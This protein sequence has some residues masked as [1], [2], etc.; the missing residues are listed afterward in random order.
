ME[1]QLTY[2][3]GHGQT[4]R[5][6]DGGEFFLLELLDGVLV[7]SQ[8]Q[9]CT[10]QDYR[11]LGTVMSHLWIPLQENKLVIFSQRLLVSLDFVFLLCNQHT[12]WILFLIYTFYL[13][14]LDIIFILKTTCVL[15]IHYK[16]Y[17]KQKKGSNYSEGLVTWSIKIN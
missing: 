15:L 16:I 11:R 7:V 6:N 9:L 4:L 13:D 10:N 5:I 17:G 3:F 12:F 8:V 14:Y 2:F 1:L